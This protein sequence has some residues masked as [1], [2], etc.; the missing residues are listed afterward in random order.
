MRV[1]GVVEQRVSS[2]W[3]HEPGCKSGRSGGMFDIK[4]STNQSCGP[5]Q[6]TS[7]TNEMNEI[8]EAIFSS[9]I[10]M[11]SCSLLISELRLLHAKIGDT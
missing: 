5:S 2:P 10:S 3:A 8:D 6:V 4:K 9:A 7:G 11:D 1:S